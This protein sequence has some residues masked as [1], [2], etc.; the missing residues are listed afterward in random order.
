M[1][2]DK[3]EGMWLQLLDKQPHIHVYC[4]TIYNSQTMETAKMPHNWQMDRENVVFIHDII[5]LFK[6]EWNFII[7]K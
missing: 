4:N 2:R 6:E 5:L 3:P 7:H 1:P